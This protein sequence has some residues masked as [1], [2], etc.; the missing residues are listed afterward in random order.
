V[1]LILKVRGKFSIFIAA[2]L[3]GLAFV[4]TRHQPP[5]GARVSLM[6]TVHYIAFFILGILVARHLAPL[7]E[8]YLS[9]SRTLRF[10]VILA[11][12]GL[13]YFS[14][15]SVRAVPQA[16]VGFSADWGI[17]LGAIGFIIV[18]L[19]EPAAKRLLSHGISAFLGR[20]SY[21][22]YLV[23]GP[24]LLAITFAVGTRISMWVQF[25]IYVIASLVLAYLFCIGVEEPFTR[26]GQ[27]LG[28]G[29]AVPT[30][31]PASVANVA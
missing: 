11:S 15:L 25:P 2:V 26:M 31:A 1:L 29:K 18:G 19:N 10:L 14:Y 22:L 20:I 3:T 13:Y 6:M 4:A 30:L 24:V 21:S 7:S 8:K 23:H 28:K 16:W 12:F 9:Q 17:V 5:Y 27:R